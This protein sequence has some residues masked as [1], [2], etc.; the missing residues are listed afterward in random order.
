MVCLI[1]SWGSLLGVGWGSGLA[2]QAT[3]GGAAS[4]V[5]L[6]FPPQ[7]THHRKPTL[8]GVDTTKHGH[9]NA[10]CRGGRVRAR[11]WPTEAAT[12]A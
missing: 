3:V 2:G 4:F 10:A 11:A 7:K 6:H 9:P 12:S 1:L 5:A 8:G